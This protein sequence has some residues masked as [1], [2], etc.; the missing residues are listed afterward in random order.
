MQLSHFVSDFVKG[1]LFH[2]VADFHSK[3]KREPGLLPPDAPEPG[4]R[5]RLKVLHFQI[6]LRVSLPLVEA[7]REDQ[8]AGAARGQEFLTAV[9]EVEGHASP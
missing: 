6:D 3:R 5:P 7:R 8:A 1:V 4:A 9:G 2:L